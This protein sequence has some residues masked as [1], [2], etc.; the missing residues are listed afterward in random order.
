MQR[1]GSFGRRR[2]VF[3]IVSLLVLGISIALDL[4]TKGYFATLDGADGQPFNLN[5]PVIK[6]FFYFTYTINEGAAFSFLHD[7]SWGQTFFKILTVIAFGFFVFLYFL[8]V[9]KN[10]GWLQIALSF[11]IGGTIG[12]FVDRVAFNYV[13]DFIGFIFGNYYFPVFNLADTFLT[14]GVIMFVIHYCFIDE[15]A[16]FKFKKKEKEQNEETGL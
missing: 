4:I 3:L 5:I 12:N 8:A 9:K 10:Y 1:T 16:I 2:I 7:V 14:V 11:I 13:R 6:D 15:N